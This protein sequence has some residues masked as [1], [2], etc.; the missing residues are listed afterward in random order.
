M[1]LLSLR[2]QNARLLEHENCAAR[3]EEAVEA[4]EKERSKGRA[5]DSI[6][7]LDMHVHTLGWK[8]IGG[9]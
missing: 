6:S 2:V 7:L 1:R 5:L 9:F 3:G 8:V 4:E